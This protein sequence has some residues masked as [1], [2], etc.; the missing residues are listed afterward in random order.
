MTSETRNSGSPR[1]SLIAVP[2][3]TLASGATAAVTR[4]ATGAHLV[5]R[6]RRVADN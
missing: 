6:E 1:A 5:E 2:T 3:T 4:L